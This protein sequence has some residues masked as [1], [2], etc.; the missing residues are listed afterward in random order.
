MQQNLTKYWDWGRKIVCVGRNYTEHCM[1][2]QN[3]VP[4][5]PLI[6]LKPTS[7][8]VHEGNSIMIPSGCSNVHHE[9]ELGVVI[10]KN[11]SQ[12]MQDAAMNHVGGYVLALDMTARDWQDKAKKAGKPWSL[13]KG[14]DTACPIS[15]FISKEEIA[16]PHNIKLWLKVNG[17]LKQEGSTSDMIFN[18]PLLISYISNVMKL[19]CGDVILTGTPEGVGPVHNGDVIDCGINDLISMKFNVEAKNKNYAN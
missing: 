18:I 8:Y 15:R 7:S 3:P 16:D 11:G 5:E 1:E 4:K 12:I 6:F 9:V 19:E 2:L 10:G 13:A 17:E 14:F